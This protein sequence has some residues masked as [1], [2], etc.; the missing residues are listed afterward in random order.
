MKKAILYFFFL[1]VSLPG[2][3]AQIQKGTLLLGGTG[4]YYRTAPKWD[5][6]RLY[7]K[8]GWALSRQLML[9]LD[10]RLAFGANQSEPDEVRF[11]VNIAPEAAYRRAFNFYGSE[12]S[13]EESARYRNDKEWSIL[14]GGD[15]FVTPN[16]AIELGLS[17]Y[18]RTFYDT[19]YYQITGQVGVQALLNPKP[20]KTS[21]K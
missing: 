6:V 11:S 18:H 17:Y 10:S 5:G 2:L 13:K 12:S 20:S 9:G 19:K 7:P 3:Q 1:W 4:I 16:F 21:K 8:I 15:F 14:A